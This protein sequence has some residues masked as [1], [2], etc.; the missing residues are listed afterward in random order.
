[1]FISIYYHLDEVEGLE[2]QDI[3][4][5]ESIIEILSNIINEH[6]KRGDNEDE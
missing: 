3:K 5:Y 4:G 1:M 2:L 6:M